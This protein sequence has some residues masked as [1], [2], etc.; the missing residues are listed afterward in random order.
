MNKLPIGEHTQE[1]LECDLKL[2]Q[3]SQVTAKDAIAYCESVQ[4]YVSRDTL[5]KTLDD[6]EE[7]IDWL[8]TRLDL[9]AKVGIGN[10]VQ[11]VMSEI[12]D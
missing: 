3:G 1:I 12:D 5:T 4:D 7:H 2:E 9:I 8:G 11:S 6:I 10:F